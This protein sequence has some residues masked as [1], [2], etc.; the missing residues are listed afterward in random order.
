MR[1]LLLAALIVVFVGPT[2]AGAQLGAR[3]VH[4][5]DIG[6]RVRIGITEVAT[7]SPLAPVAQR[8]Q[9]TVLA[10]APDTLY[11]QVSNTPSTVAIPR[12][13][14]QGV[15]TSLGVSRWQ[16]ALQ[17]GSYG[18]IIGALLLAADFAEPERRFG[19]DWYAAAVGAGAGFSGGAV[20]GALLPYEH[21]RI[22]WLPE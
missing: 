22:A 15:E 10:I 8:V 6:S 9:G 19:S 5:V 4:M 16:S 7:L 21:W 14:I 17:I 2:E 18:A 13:Q 11:L 20:I 3:T 1:R 12:I